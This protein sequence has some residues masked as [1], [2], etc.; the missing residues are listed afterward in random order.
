MSATEARYHIQRT[1]RKYLLLRIMETLLSSLAVA[2][3]IL[4]VCLLFSLKTN[5]AVFLSL[6]GGLIYFIFRSWELS[7]LKVKEKD[8]VQYINQHYAQMEESTDLL[9][10][11]DHELT[12]IQQLQKRKSIRQFESLYPSIKL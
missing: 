4:C 1:K 8:V 9:M 10:L 12:S 5:M 3:I 11:E 2:F 6:G 7:I